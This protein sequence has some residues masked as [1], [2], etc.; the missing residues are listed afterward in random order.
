MMSAF[1]AGDKVGHRC[2]VAPEAAKPPPPVVA[3]ALGDIQDIYSGEA[4]TQPTPT[5]KPEPGAGK[6]SQPGLV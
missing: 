3:L 5:P 6:T 2:H 1:R 4:A